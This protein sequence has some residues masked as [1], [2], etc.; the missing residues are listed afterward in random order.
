MPISPRRAQEHVEGWARKL[1]SRPWWPRYLFF[2][3]HVT[4]A[5]KIVHSQ[6]LRCRA[7][8]GELIEH[9]VA[10]QGAIGANPEAHN[11]VRLYFRP[12][13]HFH[14]RT[15]GIKL[16]ADQFRLPA[17]MSV[18]VMLIFDFIKVATRPDVHFCDRNM[19]H[20]GI[21]PGLDQ[22]Y[23]DSIDF[24]KVYHDA[25]IQDPMLRQEIND[26][27]MAEVLIPSSLPLKDFLSGICCRTRLDALTLRALLGQNYASVADLIRVTT[28]PAEMFF[29]WGLYL[30]ELRYADRNLT[31]KI[32]P[33][34][35]YRQGHPIDIVVEQLVN[36]SAAATWSHHGPITADPFLISGWGGQASND[37][38]ITIEDSLAFRG[39]VPVVGS[40]VV[41]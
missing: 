24:S 41:K 26:R 23:F 3:A 27:R 34:H 38:S 11:F 5:A 19:A 37:W 1:P 16:R 10:N 17:H 15:E 31:V 39:S 29:C 40:T 28:K 20:G 14:L 8:L 7:E 12:R 21:Q 18:P 9:D 4:T 22:E 36:G 32:K 25:P 2:A 13:T 30:S 35:D 6:E 33:S